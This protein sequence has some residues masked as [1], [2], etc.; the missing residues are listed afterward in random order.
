MLNIHGNFL[1]K[2]YFIPVF[3]TAY[4]EK[5]GNQIFCKYNRE[6]G[7]VMSLVVLIGAQAVGKMTVGKELE[8]IIDGKLLYNHQT[9]DI[10]ADFLGYQKATFQLSDMVRK[11]L[12]KAFVE[13]KE[14]NQTETVIFTVMIGFSETYDK[15]FLR[16]IAD[17]FL[18]KGEEVYF[19]EL[20]ADLETRIKR[21]VG[22]DRLAAK[23]S[24]RDIQ[25]SHN[26]LVSS[27]EK[28]RLVSLPGELAKIEPRA[29]TKVINNTHI[30]PS[31]TAKIIKERFNL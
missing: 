29:K 12:F 18:S 2:R 1:E 26:E 6:K 10:F 16:E 13:N 25:F 11:E 27:N 14:T 30:S 31:A 4:F 22:E 24:K 15:Q 20:V 28:H 9:I 3:E 17:I 5:I 21:N 7:D 19:V 8:K 23:P